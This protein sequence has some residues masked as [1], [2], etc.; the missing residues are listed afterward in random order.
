MWMLHSFEDLH[1]SPGHIYIY[2]DIHLTSIPK[3]GDV[4]TYLTNI[5]KIVTPIYYVRYLM[6]NLHLFE[7]RNSPP[8][9]QY[10]TK[11]GPRFII[12]MVIGIFCSD[13]VFVQLNQYSQILSTLTAT[14]WRRTSS[15]GEDLPSPRL[16]SS[17]VL[18]SKSKIMTSD[19]TVNLMQVRVCW[20]S[21]TWLF[22]CKQRPIE[23]DL[24]NQSNFCPSVGS[25]FGPR[26]D[27][28]TSSWRKTKVERL[29]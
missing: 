14:I 26:F 11:Q 17:T 12:R 27:C 1:S 5:P 7:Y 13:T 19:F 29:A 4:N 10:F 25:I 6:F 9:M 21:V 15:D 16:L 18:A 22:L 24:G 3:N 28:H 8:M 2:S 20:G 23:K